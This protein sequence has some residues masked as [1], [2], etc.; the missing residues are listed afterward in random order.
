[1]IQFEK[2]V[3]E[4][5]SNFDIFVHVPVDR[6]SEAFGLIYVEAL[7]MKVPSVFTLSGVAN[8]FIEDKVNALVVLHNDSEAIFTAMRLFLEN[9]ELRQKIVEKGRADACE[10][11]QAE[12]MAAKFDALYASM[13]LELNSQVVKYSKG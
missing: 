5:Y 10:L 2:R 13:L 7:A 9:S 11:F 6:D 12:K 1:L 3:I 4:L 8:D